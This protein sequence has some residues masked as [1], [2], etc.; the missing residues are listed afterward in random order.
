MK[1]K[2]N[3]EERE[4]PS[5]ESMCMNQTETMITEGSVFMKA[6]HENGLM[7]KENEEDKKELLGM[8]DEKIENMYEGLTQMHSFLKE[9]QI[10]VEGLEKKKEQQRSGVVKKLMKKNEEKMKQASPIVKSQLEQKNA[11]YLK[12]IVDGG[13]NDYEILESEEVE[14]LEEWTGLS[15]GEP[16]FDSH[17]DNWRSE[18]SVFNQRIVNRSQILFV[19]EDEE[20]NKFGY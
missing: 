14:Q 15:C 19:I 18:T 3:K 12:E 1:V 8:I 4:I 6:L 20:K 10:I 17:V 5:T 16:V 7:T 9:Y 2:I 13:S 11:E